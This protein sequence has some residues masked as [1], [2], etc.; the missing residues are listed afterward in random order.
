MKCFSIGLDTIFLESSAILLVLVQYPAT[1]V[2]R[3]RTEVHKRRFLEQMQ[4]QRS[5]KKQNKQCKCR[6]ENNLTV[7]RMRLVMLDLVKASG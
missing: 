2:L 4:E 5:N 1:E 7:Q 6:A 3:T